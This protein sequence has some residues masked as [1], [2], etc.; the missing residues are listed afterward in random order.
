MSLTNQIKWELAHQPE[1]IAKS[2][3]KISVDI[4]AAIHYIFME[5]KWITGES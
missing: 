2:F 1:L 5:F 3:F 4:F